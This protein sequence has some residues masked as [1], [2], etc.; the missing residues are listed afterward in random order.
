MADNAH[1]TQEFISPVIAGEAFAHDASLLGSPFDLL[2]SYELADSCS[3][4][5]NR[6]KDFV[7]VFPRS[8]LLFC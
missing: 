8:Y 5:L 7:S 4:G 6:F 2:S 1:V 3:A